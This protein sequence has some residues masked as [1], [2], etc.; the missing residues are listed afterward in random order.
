MQN[1]DQ[2][3]I[4][5]QKGATSIVHFGW[6]ISIINAMFINNVSSYTFCYFS[7]AELSFKLSV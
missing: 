1:A 4:G 7:N 5:S 2:S 3:V 6:H